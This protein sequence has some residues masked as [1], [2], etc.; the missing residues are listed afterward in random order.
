MKSKELIF[1]DWHP[2]IQAIFIFSINATIGVKFLKYIIYTPPLP[3]NIQ[4]SEGAL[5]FI[6]LHTA[7]GF[8]VSPV[9]MM[10]I[11][12]EPRFFLS[13]FCTTFITL[14][15]ALAGG[16][17]APAVFSGLIRLTMLLILFHQIQN[18]RLVA[19][20]NNIML[21]EM[22]EER[23]KNA[24]AVHALEMRHMIGNVAHDL[25]TVTFFFSS[26]YCL[27]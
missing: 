24:D 27:V 16:I 17:S 5:N 21:I 15:L 18:Q 11:I 3:D 2:L 23:E 9:I 10:A 25:K 6:S 13:A 20:V 19:F 7:S 4:V 26:P 12:Y 8:A 1:S 22:L 14:G